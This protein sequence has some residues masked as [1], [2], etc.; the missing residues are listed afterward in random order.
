MNKAENQWT[1]PMQCFPVIL[2]T[3]EKVTL[4]L[5][6]QWYQICYCPQSLTQ[7]CLPGLFER[8]SHWWWGQELMCLLQGLSGP[9]SLQ[10]SLLFHQPGKWQRST[11]GEKPEAHP[12]TIHILLC[13]NRMPSKELSHTP[14]AWVRKGDRGTDSWDGHREEEQARLLLLAAGTMLLFFSQLD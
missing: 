3:P 5:T 12:S 14:S 4:P 10:K 6:P 9:W 8:Q 1:Q 11:V 13:A 7:P 2:N